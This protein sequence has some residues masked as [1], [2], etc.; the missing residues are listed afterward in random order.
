MVE[1]SLMVLVN[2]GS[3]LVAVIPISDI[4]LVPSKEFPDVSLHKK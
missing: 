1:Y 3:Y 2:V 4:A